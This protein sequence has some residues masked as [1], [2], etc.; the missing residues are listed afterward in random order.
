MARPL[1]IEFAGGVYHVTSRGDRREPIFADDQDRACLIAILAQGLQRFDA[2]VL[3]YCLMGNH[4]HFV[5]QTRQRN[6]SRLMRHVNG[7]YSQAFNRRHGLVGHVFQGRFTAILVDRDA[8]LLE[9]CRYTD[10][11]PVRA[12]MVASAGRWPWSSYRAHAGLIGGPKWLDSTPLY[13]ALIGSERSSESRYRAARCYRSFVAEG[14][15]VRLW[16]SSLR[17][18]IYLGDEDF[19]RRTQQHLDDRHRGSR[20][21]PSA[22]LRKPKSGFMR[23]PNDAERDDSMRRAYV[24]RGMTMTEIARQAGL[25]VSRVSRIIAKVERLAHEA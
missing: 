13:D 21:I 1:R 5:L 23:Q 3:A 19:V 12:R 14:I 20:D 11:N 10:L 16:E 8:Y 6:L 9:V 25:S 2:S 24:D 18:E 22:Q 15:D 4:Y 17:Q 7:V